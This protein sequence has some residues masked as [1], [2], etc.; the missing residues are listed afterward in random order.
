MRTYFMLVFWLSSIAGGSISYAIMGKFT[1]GMSFGMGFGALIIM[2]FSGVLKQKW[3][4]GCL[5]GLIVG[6]ITM[7]F[8][9]DVLIFVL[10]L[11]SG[12]FVGVVWHIFDYKR[13]N[14][15]LRQQ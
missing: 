4:I 10:L 9:D 3:I 15:T 1:L 13:R 5:S 11:V 6:L 7:A 14:R 2:L 8:H 12:I